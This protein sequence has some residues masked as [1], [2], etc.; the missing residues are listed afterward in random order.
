MECESVLMKAGVPC[1][2]YRSVAEAMTDPQLQTR[3]FFSEL[4]KGEDRFKVANASAVLSAT[5]TQARPL[6]AGLGQH[7]GE[8]LQQLLGIDDERLASLRAS[9]T[10]GRQ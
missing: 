9:G 4:G 5:P 2:R 1:S 6:L 7:T 10:L 3:G 8:V